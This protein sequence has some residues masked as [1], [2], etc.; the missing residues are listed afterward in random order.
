MASFDRLMLT[1]YCL[2]CQS[3]QALSC[4]FMNYYVCN[5]NVQENAEAAP[6][7][8]FKLNSECILFMF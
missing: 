6:Q 8:L 4:T 7:N 1:T 3:S 2:L 5:C